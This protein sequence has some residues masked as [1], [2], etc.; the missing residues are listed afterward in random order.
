MIS[1]WFV[2]SAFAFSNAGIDLLSFVIALYIAAAWI[3]VRVGFS[4]WQQMLGKRLDR[5][6]RFRLL[7]AACIALPLVLADVGVFSLIR[8]T[9]SEPALLDYAKNV[10]A[11]KI[12]MAFE[13]RHS[14]RN[15]GLYTVTVT[16][17]LSDGTVRV[18]TSRAG[19]FDNAG[20]AHTVDGAPPE[21]YQNRYRPIYR[22]WWHWTQKW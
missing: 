17:L 12:D 5:P 19:M 18:I 14:P 22:E 11:R 2:G 13:F 7:E 15:V 9:L 21:Q 8:F 16:D 10:R 6:W 20:F 3:V 4:L 1:F